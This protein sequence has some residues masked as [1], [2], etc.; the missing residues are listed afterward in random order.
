LSGAAWSVGQFACKP[1]PAKAIEYGGLGDR[2]PVFTFYS[3]AGDVSVRMESLGLNPRSV[4]LELQSSKKGDFAKSW[5]VGMMGNFALVLCYGTPTAMSSNTCPFKIDTDG[6][7]HLT[8]AA[9][10]H[11]GVKTVEVEEEKAPL[12]AT[13][14]GS[15]SASAAEAEASAGSAEGSA[16]GSAT[17][18]EDKA[19]AEIADLG[20]SRHDV[21]HNQPKQSVK[22]DARLDAQPDD[23]GLGDGE[24]PET[25]VSAKKVWWNSESLEDRVSL[26]QVDAGQP[27]EAEAKEDAEPEASPDAEPKS[28]PASESDD[29]PSK[30]G[31]KTDPAEYYTKI[32]GEG[33]Q[34]P[35]AKWLTENGKIGVRVESENALEPKNVYLELRNKG[36]RDAWGIGMRKDTYFYMGY[37]TLGTYGLGTKKNAMKMAPSKDITFLKDVVFYKMPSYFKPGELDLTEVGSMV[38]PGSQEPEYG[39]V[40]KAKTNDAVDVPEVPNAADDALGTTSS[41]EPVVSYH[42][43][44]NLSLRISAESTAALKES[45]LEIRSQKKRSWRIAVHSDGELYFTFHAAASLQAGEKVMKVTKDGQV[46]FYGEANF[47]GKTMKKF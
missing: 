3:T 19:L 10:F 24:L 21:M 41:A 31:G 44:D 27:A 22:I 20:E 43:D 39:N 35:A 2:A 28:E 17:E 26:L 23:D 37:G 4:Y 25:A 8:G 11:G 1:V 18:T 34:T 36:R 9:Y 47:G 13:G 6:T 45:F 15:G 12:L 16:A 5:M 32:G 14:S 38:E 29:E 40:Y 46:H 33:P 7:V 30:S 42:S